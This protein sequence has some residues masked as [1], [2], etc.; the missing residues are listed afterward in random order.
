M[1]HKPA[2]ANDQVQEDRQ[3]GGLSG[4]SAIV[5]N[6]RRTIRVEGGFADT[7]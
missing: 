5:P 1:R 7:I 4:S 2:A 3:H 6:E